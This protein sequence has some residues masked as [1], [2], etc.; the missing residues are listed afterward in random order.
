MILLV[1]EAFS[2]LLRAEWLMRR[3]GLYAL[4][5]FLE[6]FPTRTV[7]SLHFSR[8]QHCY[9]VDIACVLY[10]KN[11]MCLQR[12]AATAMLLRQHGFP[13]EL[14]IGAQILPF[15]S[16][17]WVELNGQVVND[18]SYMPKIYRELDRC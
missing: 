10:A 14:V 1:I 2:N 9:A 3:R 6:R 5:S 12:S 17:A 4:H 13:A 11:V 8:D 7:N 18:K 15:R 16:H